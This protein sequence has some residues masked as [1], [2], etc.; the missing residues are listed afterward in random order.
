MKKDN[1]FWKKIILGGAILVGLLI[2]VFFT[3][4]GS[5]PGGSSIERQTYIKYQALMDG[6]SSKDPETLIHKAVDKAPN[7]ALFIVIYKR[8]CPKCQEYQAAVQKEV[9]RYK[10][11]GNVVLVAETS[12]KGE[13]T[14]YPDWL[15]KF[16]LPHDET[17]V[18]VRYDLSS[19]SNPV[20]I[21]YSSYQVYGGTG[22]NWIWRSENMR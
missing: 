6:Q 4:K 16:Q 12:G 10:K 11:N 21:K 22:D 8:T 15:T 7:I 9:E 19:V 13:A 5:L 2:G 18:I 17:P 1:Q 20:P 3:S 14:S